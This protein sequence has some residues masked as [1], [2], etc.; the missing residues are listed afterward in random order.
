MSG[1]RQLDLPPELKPLGKSINGILY[2]YKKLIIS[3]TNAKSA[4]KKLDTKLSTHFTPPAL[5]IKT[6]VSLPK[7]FKNEENKVNETIK[8]T[9]KILTDIVYNVRLKSLNNLITKQ[10]EFIESNILSV[11]ESFTGTI[12]ELEMDSISEHLKRYLTDKLPSIETSAKLK[13]AVKAKSKSDSLLKTE[14]KKADVLKQ[15]PN[16]KSV[17]DVCFEVCNSLME[18]NFKHFEAKISKMLASKTSNQQ[19]TQYSQPLRRGRGGGRHRGRGRG[20]YNSTKPLNY[21]NSVN[22]ES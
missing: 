5:R 12:T 17:K 9:E 13:I 15:G 1:E 14:E 22:S 21:S 20:R 16:G 6:Q 11:A 7:G 10:D 19:L 2:E 8:Q 18:R 4:V 3:I